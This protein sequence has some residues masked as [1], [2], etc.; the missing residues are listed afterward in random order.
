MQLMEDGFETD[1]Q[2][3]V[4]NSIQHGVSSFEELI[5][6]LPGVYPTV[7]LEAL[8]NLVERS[9][10][11]QLELERLVSGAIATRS[12]VSEAATLQLPSPHPLDYSWW[13]DTTTTH[14]LCD[15]A[16]NLEYDDDLIILLG[17]PRLFMEL[18]EVAPTRNLLLLDSDP[19]I[20]A[21]LTSGKPFQTIRTCDVIRD[22]LPQFQGGLVLLDPPW[23]EDEIRSFLWSASFLVNIGGKIVVTLPSVGTRPHVFNE[24]NRI[25]HWA[26]QLGLILQDIEEDSI[27][28]LSPPFEINALAASGVHNVPLN[29]RQGSFAT[30]EKIQRP[31]VSRPSRLPSERWTEQAIG[32]VRIRVRNAERNTWESPLLHPLVKGDILPSVS[33]RDPRRRRVD[34]WTSGNRIFRCSGGFVLTQVLSAIA[35]GSAA[36]SVVSSALERSLTK[37]ED[38]EVSCAVM[39]VEKLVLTESAELAN[40]GV[41]H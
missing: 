23:Y 13:F 17:T 19:L 22:A 18:S 32:E 8:R 28:Y 9:R 39:A 25:L 27:A 37:N 26:I 35:V 1:V 2:T 12:Q 5:Q 30:F 24:R 38:E 20:K 4:V 15:R 41:V 40:K 21:R 31:S 29:W 16:L 7:A 11:D 3:W 10:I 34:V 33:R 36:G 6:S 14:K